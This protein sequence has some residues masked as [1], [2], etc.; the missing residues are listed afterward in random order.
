[1]EFFIGEESSKADDGLRSI[2]NFNA[3]ERLAWNRRFYTERVRGKFASYQLV[4]TKAGG[5]A[6]PRLVRY[7]K[8]RKD[9][10]ARARAMRDDFEAGN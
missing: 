8:L 6:K 5:P 2:W 3:D 7:H 9:A 4:N 10:K 1:M